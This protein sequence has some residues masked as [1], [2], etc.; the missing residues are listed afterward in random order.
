MS[1]SLVGTATG[2]TTCT[3]PA[4]VA[5]DLILISGFRT[6][7][8]SPSLP[9]GYLPVANGNGTTCS[10]RIGYKIADGTGDTSGT[11]TNSAALV[12]H[13]YRASSGFTL[14]IGARSAIAHQTTN[15]INY[16]AITMADTSGNSWVAGFAGVNNLT[17]TIV[18]APSGMTNE[19]HETAAA[20]Q[21]AGH[22]TEGG[23]T[24]W[25]STNAT[26]TGTAG[27][28]CSAVV[29]ILLLSN[30]AGSNLANVYG[31][32]GGGSNPNNNGGG[33]S[34][35]THYTLPVPWNSGTGNLYILA[36][37]YDS[38][39]GPSVSDSNNG[40]WGTAALVETNAGA[41]DTSVFV[42]P[43]IASGFPIITVTYSTATLSMQWTL[44][45]LYHIAASSPVNG[46]H[47]S[48]N[49][50]GPSVSAGSFT[51][52]T[53]PNVIWAYTSKTVVFDNG[54]TTPSLIVAGSGFTLLDADIS[55]TTASEAYSASHASE[56]F[57]QATAAAINPGFSVVGDTGPY[58]TLAVALKVDNSQGT[59]PPSSGIW[60]PKVISTSTQGFPTSATYT[61]Q[62]PSLGNLRCIACP[63]P[64]LNTLTVRDS[65]GNIWTN[66]AAAGGLWFL[67]NASPNPNLQVFID[68]G[69]GTANVSWRYFDIIGASSSPYDSF[70]TP[71]A[72]CPN[73]TTITLNV[74][75]SPSNTNGLVLYNVELGTGPGLAV[76]APSGA[77]WYLSN[78]TGQTDN[79][80]MENSDIGAFYWNTAS[81]AI[82][83]T[84]TIT[85]EAGN[86]YL[87]GFICFK[88]GA[89]AVSAAFR[90]L[91]YASA[92]MATASSVAANARSLSAA[93]AKVAPN[94]NLATTARSIS[95]GFGRSSPGL[96]VGASARS[97][98]VG[99]AHAAG[100]GTV[101]AAFRTLSAG[102]SHVAGA[103]RVAAALKGLSAATGRLAATTGS[104]VSAALKSLSAAH[105]KA[106]A[107]SSVAGKG[108]SQSNAAA[109]M[110]GAGIVGAFMISSS[111]S[112]DSVMPALS[113]AASLKAMSAAFAKAA[114]ASRVGAAMRSLSAAYGKLAGQSGSV[115][116]AA[117][118]SISAA[119]ARAAPVSTVAGA[120]RGMSAATGRFTGSLGNS[121]I[122]S[123]RSLS[124][125]FGR[126][127]PASSVAGAARSASAA[128][129]RAAGASK[130]AAAM[131]SLSASCGRLV[132]SIGSFV[133]AAMRSLSAAMGKTVAASKVAATVRSESAA[134]GRASPA[135][136]IAAAVRSMSSAR[137]SLA[138]TVGSV[139]AAALRSRSAAFGRLT[140]GNPVIGA[141]LHSVSFA[142]AGVTGTGL[143]AA[144]LRGLSAAWA[145]LTGPSGSTAVKAVAT[146]SPLW[147][148]AATDGPKWEAVAGLIPNESNVGSL[149]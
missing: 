101:A 32:R 14:G 93:H 63:D 134:A 98:S 49:A 106:A 132:P 99:L 26:T 143:T 141:S 109:K 97:S 119:Y 58:N 37:T 149:L 91:S 6:A 124:A 112:D 146:D 59:P 131:R 123:L 125:G 137:A 48:A 11:W 1:I 78:Y 54:A 66:T 2:T 19:S 47:G 127:A 138:A 102:F 5:G 51:P 87:G 45:E 30:S 3:I 148:A 29:E 121:V 35:S 104:L 82:T 39:S 56:V 86:S 90:G 89:A 84:F 65:E 92:K 24:S 136:R 129:G 50:N 88:A 94:L 111:A 73:V 40:S 79:D 122:A 12:C 57:V 43:N 83:S 74:S 22:D 72:S 95:S 128:Q 130:V 44:T 27:D 20:A 67:A 52:G 68:G 75:P 71:N 105:A 64:A 69:G 8:G 41:Q 17:N 36:L 120:A 80:L 85:S 133:F 23:V 116:T 115:V 142:S 140:R 7:T 108:E 139:V 147:D 77:I 107:I 28:S 25:S 33:Q 96:S 145:R 46:T 38:G 117:L 113:L 4:H 10:Q 62:C 15:T 16:P 55:E 21:A 76:T 9:A 31:H 18:T 53:G 114:G 70:G 42:I 126:A 61:L 34:S 110:A 13:V 103:S 118:R 144:F 81:G 60:V 135:L 100:A